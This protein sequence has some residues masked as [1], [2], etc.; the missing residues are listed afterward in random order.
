MHREL[1]R[2]NMTVKK[3]VR[4]VLF[5]KTL[6]FGNY[7]KM[8]TVQLLSK[9]VQDECKYREDRYF[10][11]FT[12][13]VKFSSLHGPK[14]ELLDNDTVARRYEGYCYSVAFSK[15][16]LDVGKTLHFNISE[17]ETGWLANLNVGIIYKDPFDIEDLVTCTANIT[18]SYNDSRVF[19][20]KEFYSSNNLYQFRIDKEGVAYLSPNV[21]ADDVVFRGVDVT[22]SFWA[23]FNVFGDSKAVQLLG[24]SEN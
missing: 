15:S 2:S 9:R 7:C 20:F 4:F 24:I 11:Y 21:T 23:I 10:L 8:E 14:I 19:I 12:E 17:I 1:K 13:E 22:K 18:E 6:Q 16:P 3:L 5:W